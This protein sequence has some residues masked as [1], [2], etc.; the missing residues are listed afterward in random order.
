MAVSL[1]DLEL[2]LDLASFDSLVGDYFV[3]VDR[4]SGQLYYDNDGSED[5]IPEDIDD[6]KKYLL[7]PE[8][9]DLDLGKRLVLNFASEYLPAQFDEVYAI[10]NR[11][12]AYQRYKALL[13]DL[14]KLEDWYKY[15][16]EK[17][18]E[19]LVQWCKENDIEVSL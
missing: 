19:A 1:S 12:G 16:T 3:Y 15:E 7:I 4:K 11:K 5:E 8:K 17:T 14:G 18:K 13:T 6:E 9:Q 10:F 2:A